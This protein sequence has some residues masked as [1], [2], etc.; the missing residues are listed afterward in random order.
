MELKVT[1]QTATIANGATDSDVIRLGSHSQR[2]GFILPAA[3]TGATIGFKGAALSTDTFKTISDAAGTPISIPV[4]ADEA[5]GVS[6]AAL[7]AI[8][9][10]PYL[11]LVSGSAEGAAR[12]ITV[13][14]K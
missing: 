5:I 9:A 10:F 1:T 2:F 13:F 6:G 11:K 7:D 4:A 14:V 12:S 8:L 3:L